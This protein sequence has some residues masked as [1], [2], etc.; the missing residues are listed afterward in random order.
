MI[1]QQY[2]RF[3]R[4]IVLSSALFT[5]LLVMTTTASAQDNVESVLASSPLEEIAGYVRLNDGVVWWHHG[6]GCADGGGDVQNDGVVE[7]VSGFRVAPQRTVDVDYQESV[8]II[9]HAGLLFQG[10]REA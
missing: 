2:I 10:S 3:V 8:L 4:C 9:C 7:V 1:P 5:F 6:T